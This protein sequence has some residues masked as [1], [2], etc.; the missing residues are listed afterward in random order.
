MTRELLI[1]IV[2]GFFVLAFVLSSSGIYF[3]VD[4]SKLEAQIDQYSEDKENLRAKYLSKISLHKLDRTAGKLN[5]QQ[6]SS[7]LSYSVSEKQSAREY[8]LLKKQTPRTESVVLV[9]GY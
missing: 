5:M 7:A 6:A 2:L 1:T 3:E 4:N 9:S 8:K